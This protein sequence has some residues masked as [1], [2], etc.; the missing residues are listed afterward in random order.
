MF[1]AQPS[2]KT[3]SHLKVMFI[4]FINYNINTCQSSAFS[5]ITAFIDDCNWVFCRFSF[6]VNK[7]ATSNKK[8]N[9]SWP[10]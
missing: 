2:R 1:T 10:Q 5:K 8:T 9:D 4:N 7:I 3:I 6:L